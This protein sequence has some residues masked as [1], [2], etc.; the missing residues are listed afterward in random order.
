MSRHLP[1]HPSL[2]FLKKEAKTLLQDLQR[3]DAAARL[4]DAQHQL[5][6]EYGFASWPKL[7]AFVETAPAPHPLA[8]TWRL[9]VAKSSR[10][11]DNAVRSATV[12]FDIAGDLVTIEDVTVSESG[13]ESRTVNQLHADSTERAGAHGYAMCVRWRNARTLE[14]EARQH[15]G[16]IGSGTYELS[17]DGSHM[18]ASS[19]GRTFVF[20]RLRPE[21]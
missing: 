16:A 2:E 17:P 15:G 13:E 6:R 11:P 14:W 1:P 18:I 12:R 8:G 3:R 4:A 5:A 19:V 10:H 21:A 7:K 20:D 9:D